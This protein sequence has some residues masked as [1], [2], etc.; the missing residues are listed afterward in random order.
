M[1]L[2]LSQK[3]SGRSEEEFDGAIRDQQSREDKMIQT[4]T[5]PDD[6]VYIPMRTFNRIIEYLKF[7]GHRENEG[8]RSGA[9]PCA[10]CEASA[11]LFSLGE[12]KNSH[13]PNPW[14]QPEIIDPVID[15]IKQQ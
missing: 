15:T 8:C 10:N 4:N 6:G 9:L 7:A 13:F 2:T 11:I 3:Y 1:E 14:P 5:V 12:N